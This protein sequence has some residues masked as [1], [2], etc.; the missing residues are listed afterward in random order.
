MSHTAKK[1][2]TNND[3]QEELERADKQNNSNVI[4]DVVSLT[5][6]VAFELMVKMQ[7]YNELDQEELLLYCRF[8]LMLKCMTCRYYNYKIQAP[9]YLFATIREAMEIVRIIMTGELKRRFR[10][11]NLYFEYRYLLKQRIYQENQERTAPSRMIKDLEKYK[12]I[13]REKEEEY[14]KRMVECCKLLETRREKSREK[15]EK[16]T[17]DKKKQKVE[18]TILTNTCDTTIRSLDEEI[19]RIDE[20]LEKLVKKPH[21]FQIEEEACK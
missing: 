17:R 1:Q 13:W 20:R 9:C 11:S 8:L 21:Q 15:K 10:Y 6:K 14:M 5:W 4:I 18:D 12:K 16:M 7:A 19:R 3:E 2:K